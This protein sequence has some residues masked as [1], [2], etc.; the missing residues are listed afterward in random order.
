[1]GFYSEAVFGLSGWLV[2]PLVG[3]VGGL[4]PPAGSAPTPDGVPAPALDWPLFRRANGRAALT[5]A[6]KRGRAPEMTR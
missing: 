2:G 4:A 3:V 6:T 1:M 5:S